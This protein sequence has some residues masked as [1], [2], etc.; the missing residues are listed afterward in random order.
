LFGEI[1]AFFATIKGVGHSPMVEAPTETV[2]LIEDF[3]K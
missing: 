2:K 3:L 1:E